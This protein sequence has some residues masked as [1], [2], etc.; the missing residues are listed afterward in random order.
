M[1]RLS[2]SYFR[3]AEWLFVGL[4]AIA[5]GLTMHWTFNL[6]VLVKGLDGQHRNS[7]E[8][9][10]IHSAFQGD[11]PQEIAFGGERWD[12]TADNQQ[13]YCFQMAIY[14]PIGSWYASIPTLART[15]GGQDIPVLER[16]TYGVEEAAMAA[17]FTVTALLSFALL[18]VLLLNFRKPDPTAA[19]HRHLL[20][21]ILL[22]VFIRTLFSFGYFIV[23]VPNELDKLSLQIGNDYY[24]DAA[25]WA[26]AWMF[27]QT[28]LSAAFFWVLP[29]LFIASN[30]TRV[31]L[32]TMSMWSLSTPC[33]LLIAAVDQYFC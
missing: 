18:G 6:Q 7:L 8:A 33:L 26:L 4:G 16:S 10:Q 32:L 13:A 29:L 5:L 2:A 23:S 1:T 17:R 31:T 25:L 9:I 20:G 27:V 24:F 12:V 30:K 15:E 14:G 28:A 11:Q 19:L 21:A 3:P 22:F